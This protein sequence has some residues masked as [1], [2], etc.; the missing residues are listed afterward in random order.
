MVTT[1]V[2]SRALR[3]GASLRFYGVEQRHSKGAQRDLFDR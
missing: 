2:T 1:T 3:L